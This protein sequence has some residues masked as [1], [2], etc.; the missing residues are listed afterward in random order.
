MLTHIH[1]YIYDCILQ[2]QSIKPKLSNTQKDSDGNMWF[3]PQNISVRKS[4]SSLRQKRHFLP[5]TFS[6]SIPLRVT[7]SF[8]RPR[9]QTKPGLSRGKCRNILMHPQACPWESSP[10]SAKK[11][12]FK[13]LKLSF[14][15]MLIGWTIQLRPWVAVFLFFQSFRRSTASL[16]NV[17]KIFHHAWNKSSVVDTNNL[18]IF[19]SYR[20]QS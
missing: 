18:N 12:N 6:L 10:H 20:F 19:Y 16:G 15:S 7:Y 17:K 2:T 4:T 13:W 3:S 14:S 5:R 11:N 9:E 1:W 8:L